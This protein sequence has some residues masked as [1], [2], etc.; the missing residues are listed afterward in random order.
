VPERCILRLAFLAQRPM[1][2]GECSRVRTF[3][4]ALVSERT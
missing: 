1:S 4:I 2:G 3:M